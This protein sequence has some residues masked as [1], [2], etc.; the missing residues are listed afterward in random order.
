M[1]H[2]SEKHLSLKVLS[3]LWMATMTK[4]KVNWQLATDVDQQISL[5]C[6]TG[7]LEMFGKIMTFGEVMDE[8]EKDY[9]LLP[10]YRW[11]I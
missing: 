3:I 10:Q 8:V 1:Q 9:L 6:P 4:V 5:L 2:L 11:R 7:A